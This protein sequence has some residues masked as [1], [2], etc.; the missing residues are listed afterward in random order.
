ME[1]TFD[2]GAVALLF[3]HEVEERVLRF[4]QLVADGRHLLVEL[5]FLLGVGSLAVDQR[6]SEAVDDAGPVERHIDAGDAQLQSLVVDGRRTPQVQSE[7]TG[8]FDDVGAQFDIIH[9]TWIIIS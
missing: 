2:P 5:D 9:R 6:R 7:F 1:D 3:G 8:V 4:L